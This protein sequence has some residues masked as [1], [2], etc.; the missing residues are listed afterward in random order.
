MIESAKGLHGRNTPLQGGNYIN[1][2]THYRPLDDPDWY[3]RE[4][5]EGTP[6]PLID[7]GEC[8]LE[9]R[10]DQYSQ[11]A[12]VCDNKAIGP[13]LSPTVSLIFVHLLNS[14]LCTDEVKTNLF[15]I[16]DVQSK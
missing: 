16:I 9:G 12:V 4:N 1:L 5:P 15:H 10:L 11:G 13:N 14:L 2:F 7:V 6:E 8:H 3:R